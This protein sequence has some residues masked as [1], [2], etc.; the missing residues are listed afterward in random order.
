M[1]EQIIEAEVEEIEERKKRSRKK[2]S[3]KEVG[4]PLEVQ[5]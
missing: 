2:G 3:P 4:N 5:V 1:E